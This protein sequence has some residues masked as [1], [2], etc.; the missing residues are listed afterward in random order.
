[1]CKCVLMLGLHVAEE[2]GGMIDCAIGEYVDLV[3]ALKL[4]I[5]RTYPCRLLHHGHNHQ[6]NRRHHLQKNHSQP[7]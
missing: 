7:C 4:S 6:I 3:H 2:E 1:M 5:I